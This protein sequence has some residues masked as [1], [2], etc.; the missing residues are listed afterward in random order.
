MGPHISFYRARTVTDCSHDGVAS[1]LLLLPMNDQSPWL[2]GLG[3]TF[4]AAWTVTTVATV[5]GLWLTTVLMGTV[6]H[7]LWLPKSDQCLWLMGFGSTSYGPRR[8]TDG[9]P[10]YDW[11][12]YNLLK[13]C[14]AFSINVCL[15]QKLATI[16][17]IAG[18]HPYMIHLWGWFIDSVEQC[19]NTPQYLNLWLLLKCIGIV[20]TWNFQCKVWY[21]NTPYTP[22]KWL[23]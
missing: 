5:L 18:P 16:G 4:Y 15:F 12:V 10:F 17:T 9:G 11:V 8:V 22:Y 6:L 3:N 7:L 2:M 13:E 21:G 20:H 1:Q 14:R 19:R 23:H